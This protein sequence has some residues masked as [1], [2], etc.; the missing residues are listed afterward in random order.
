[1]SKVSLY[2]TMINM[3]DN[4]YRELKAANAADKVLIALDDASTFIALAKDGGT[5]DVS[6]AIKILMAAGLIEEADA[7]F[8]IW[9][10]A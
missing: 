2:D 7:I 10:E 8:K 9:W 5:G 4:I 1:M 3:L 6:I